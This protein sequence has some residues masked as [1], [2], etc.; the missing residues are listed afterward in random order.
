MGEKEI[1]KKIDYLKEHEDKIVMINAK[2]L[3]D[4]LGL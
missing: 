1:L 4:V 2:Q 3:K